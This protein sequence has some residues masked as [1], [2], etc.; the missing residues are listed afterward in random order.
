MRID[1]FLFLVSLLAALTGLLMEDITSIGLQWISM[2]RYLAL[3]VLYVRCFRADFSFF[4]PILFSVFLVSLSFLGGHYSM[5]GLLVTAMLPINLYVYSK[6][7]FSRREISIIQLLLL[8]SYFLYALIAFSGI[9]YINP[10]QVSF[11]ILILTVILFFC[12]YTRTGGKRIVIHT[13]KGKKHVLAPPGL[14]TL[15]GLSFVLIL[16]TES[17]N[18][19]LVYILLVAAFIVRERVA[20][21][22]KWGLLLFALLI[23]Y[24]VYPPVYC[25]LSESFGGASYNTE[26][27][28]QDIFSGREYIWS[29]IYAQLIDPTAFFFGNIDTEWWGKSMHNSALDIVVRYGFPAMVIVELII[30][31]YFIKYSRIIN[32][33]YKPLLCLVLVAMIWGVNESGLFLG[34]SFYL[35]LPCCILRSKNREDLLMYQKTGSK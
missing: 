29:Y 10:N 16:L 33:K 8:F 17:R 35:F 7:S 34:F 30:L 13:F 24:V 9:K 28:G 19:L 26:M 4:L 18:S 2:I 20:K 31:Y 5:I 3:L 21:W 14:L 15:L 12:I 11:K 6:I 32:N 27:M 1:F 22:N 23:L 25:L